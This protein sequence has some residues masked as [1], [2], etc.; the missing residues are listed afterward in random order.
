MD[1]RT[2]H[3]HRPGKHCFDRCDVFAPSGDQCQTGMKKEWN[4]GS[5]TGG[6]GLQLGDGLRIAKPAVDMCQSQECGSRITRSTTKACTG[7]DALTDGYL[8][9]ALI[10][11]EAFRIQPGGTKDNVLVSSQRY[12]WKALDQQLGSWLDEQNIG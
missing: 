3:Q 1:A 2:D 10:I 8:C 9:A 12:L 6:K 5:A 4:I 7:R 11:G